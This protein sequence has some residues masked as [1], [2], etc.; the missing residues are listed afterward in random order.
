MMHKLLVASRP[1]TRE[2]PALAVLALGALVVGTAEL[3]VVGVLDLIGHG[4]GVTESSAGLTVTSYALGICLGGPTL[5]VLTLPIRRRTLLATTLAGYAA[6]NLLAASSTG[7]GVLVTARFVA[8]CLHGL[9]MGVAF[10]VAS[11]LVPPGRQGRAISLVLGGI[12]AAMIA[13]VPLGTTIGHALGWRSAFVAVGILGLLAATASALVL[14]PSPTPPA[15]SAR[16]QARA[17]FKPR[18]LMML[19]VAFVLLGGQFS[20]FT[21]LAPFLEKVTGSSP[22]SVSGYLLLFGIAAAIGTVVGGRAADRNAHRTIVLAGCTLVVIFI[23]LRSLGSSPTAVA[24]LLAAWGFVGIGLVPALQLRIVQLGEGGDLAA[25][26]GASAINGG[27]AAGAATGGA[28]ASA[29]G[30]SNV[31]TLASAVS[32][33][34]VAMAAGLGAVPRAPRLGRIHVPVKPA[35]HVKVGS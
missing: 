13:G 31:C 10:V 34:G 23:L 11:A 25:T 32:L 29:F 17:V 3:L 19:G 28:V 2:T 16:G 18:S 14:P 27:I 30:L 22:G 35:S 5:T 9:F 4:L 1:R 12:T 24:V 15:A 6:A 7:F 26:L 8:G 20:A 33:V 21:F